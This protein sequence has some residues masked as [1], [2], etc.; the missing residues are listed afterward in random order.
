MNFSDNFLQGGHNLKKNDI[1]YYRVRFF[2]YLAVIAFTLF[3]I[4]IIFDSLRGDY[5][6]A[7][8]ELFLIILLIGAL[9]ILRLKNGMRAALIIGSLIIFI[10]CLFNFIDGG[11]QTAGILWIFIFPPVIFLL[12]GYKFGVTWASVFISILI[13]FGILDAAGVYSLKYNSYSIWISIIIFFVI[14]IIIIIFSR[15]QDKRGKIISEQSKEVS[16]TSKKLLASNKELKIAIEERQK[17]IEELK[18]EKENAEKLSKAMVGRE[19]RIIEL[20]EEVK[21]LKSG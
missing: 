2:N 8:I 15:L 17:I 1:Q 20:K 3:S 4:F 11:F 6:S 14:S 9:L 19:N 5:L 7:G 16:K 21:K 10:L 13:I 18:I 12:R